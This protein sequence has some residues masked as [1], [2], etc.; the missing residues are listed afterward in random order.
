VVELHPYEEPFMENA[1]ERP[2]L[3]DFLSVSSLGEE[4]DEEEEK[5]EEKEEKAQH[6]QIDVQES[7][8]R[9]ERVSNMYSLVLSK[10]Y[11]YTVVQQFKIGPSTAIQQVIA[12]SDRV[13]LYAV[14]MCCNIS[15]YVATLVDLSCGSLLYICIYNPMTDPPLSAMRELLLNAQKERPIFLVVILPLLDTLTTAL[16]GST[17]MRLQTTHCTQFVSTMCDFEDMLMKASSGVMSQLAFVVPVR[18][19]YR[20]GLH[21]N[22]IWESAVTIFGR[23]QCVEALLGERAVV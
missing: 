3:D 22:A 7:S 11:F 4:E 23:E 15:N 9:A 2:A 6:V 5:D 17:F 12:P 19:S 8:S 21:G 1:S 20:N 10:S 18:D 14:S 16:Q 13:N